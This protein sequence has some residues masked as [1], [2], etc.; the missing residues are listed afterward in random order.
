MILEIRDRSSRG[1]R[2]GEG[3]APA[4]YAWTGGWEFNADRA[5]RRALD[6]GKANRIRVTI[7]DDRITVDLEE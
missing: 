5:S 7:E 2:L 4:R 1:H 3:S 6:N